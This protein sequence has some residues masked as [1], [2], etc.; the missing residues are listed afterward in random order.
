MS[1]ILD[2]RVED[3]FLYFLMLINEMKH[4]KSSLLSTLQITF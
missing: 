1:F 3:D 2:L 4:K